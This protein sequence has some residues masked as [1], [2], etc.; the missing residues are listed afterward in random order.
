M[1]KRLIMTVHGLVQGVGF[2][3][4]VSQQARHLD[5][6]GAV[7][8]LES[9]SVGIVAEGETSQLE[10]LLAWTQQGPEHARVTSVETVWGDATGEFD[11]FSV[12]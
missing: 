11:G 12:Q 2:R 4:A 10:Q 6:S 7:R 5:L 9:G 3:H 8:N 1:H